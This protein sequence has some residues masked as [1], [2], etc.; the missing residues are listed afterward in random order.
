MDVLQR[1]GLSGQ[2]GGAHPLP[3]GVIAVSSGVILTPRARV[4]AP[5]RQVLPA[6]YTS[7]DLSMILGLA[8]HRVNSAFVFSVVSRKRKLQLGVRLAPGKVEVHVGPRDSVSFAYDVHD[9]RWH[10]LALDI[11]GRRVFLYTACGGRTAHADLVPRKAESLD[12]EGS[13]ILGRM[14]QN[15]VPFEGAICQFDIYPSAQAAHNYCD[16]I[17]KQCREA[18]SFRPAL[19]PLLP[20][21]PP[22]LSATVGHATPL[23]WTQRTE[24]AQKAT[25][26]RPEMRR[27]TAAQPTRSS[28]AFNKS[29]RPTRASP[30]LRTTP[31]SAPV[32]RGLERPLKSGPHTVTATPTIIHRPTPPGGPDRAPLAAFTEPPKIESAPE[33]TAAARPGSSSN[34]D[35]LHQK[36]LIT[37]APKKLQPRVTETADVEPTAARVPVTPAAADGS[38]IFNLEPTQSALLLGPPGQKGEPGPVVSS[39]SEAT[40]CKTKPNLN[41]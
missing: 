28:P 33:T 1:L 6:S 3:T 13:F 24:K 25:A 2:R 32:H 38:Q 14:N 36:Q 11:R 35:L 34:T 8:A 4:Q 20:L 17:K 5:L 16:Y 27:A 9:G 18:D 21:L 15:S 40:Q 30:V 26:G 19:P 10:S 7:T 39:L 37:T 31:V 22:E 41:T 23:S 12:P 29:V